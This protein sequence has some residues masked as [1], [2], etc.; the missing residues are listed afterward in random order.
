[1]T[2][3]HQAAGPGMEVVNVNRRTQSVW[4][5]REVLMVILFRIQT[6]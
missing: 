2:A 3:D 1:M 5:A 4:K 6:V